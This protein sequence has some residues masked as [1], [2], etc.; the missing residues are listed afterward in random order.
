MSRKS[1]LASA[2]TPALSHQPTWPDQHPSA[3]ASQA[4]QRVVRMPT[5]T[6]RTGLSRSHIY[7]EIRGG[8]FPTPVALGARAV[9]W[10]ESEIDAWIARRIA[11]SRRAT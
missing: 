1:L 4:P 9:G 3:C 5:V 10:L 8:R 6:G 11:A 7:A 2:H